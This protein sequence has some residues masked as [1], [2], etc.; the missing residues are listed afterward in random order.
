MPGVF[1]PVKSDENRFSATVVLLLQ[2]VYNHKR[3]KFRWDRSCAC[4]RLHTSSIK[5]TSALGY[6]VLLKHLVWSNQSFSISDFSLFLWVW[7]RCWQKFSVVNHISRNCF[8]TAVIKCTPW[9]RSG[10]K[11]GAPNYMFKYSSSLLS[12]SATSS[13]CPKTEYLEQK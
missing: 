5:S 13:F 1:C 11:E 2:L 4:V 10:M 3:D 9:V 12:M 7:P 8:K 6:F